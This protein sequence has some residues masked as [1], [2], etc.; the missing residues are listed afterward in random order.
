MATQNNNIMS[1]DFTIIN[2]GRQFGSG[3]RLVAQE[4][5]RKLG[6]SVYDNELISKAAEESGFSKEFFE[7]SDERRSLFNLSFL[8]DS[9]RFGTGRNFVGDNELFRIQSTVIRDIAEKGPAIFVGR[10]T[11]YILRDKKCLDVFITAPMEDR[12][13][14]VAS[15]TGTSAEEAKNRIEKCDR[16]RQTYYNF[17]TY[18]EWGVASNYDLCIDSSILGI[19]GTADLIIEFGK[20]TGI[21]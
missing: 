1:N 12:I 5:S 9:G 13:K 16:T 17:F 19:N 15:R 4:I 7:K 10:C 8:V 6:I 18:G 20:K 21:I 2:I 14:R 3:G 11:N